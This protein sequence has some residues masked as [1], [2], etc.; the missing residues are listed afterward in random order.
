VKIVRTVTG[1]ALDLVW[2][3]IAS[4][5]DR[6]AALAIMDQA[7]MS[8]KPFLSHQ[9]ICCDDCSTREAAKTC[10]PANAGT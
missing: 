10:R 9:C 2:L 3:E 4:G 6:D 1:A 7:R 8:A 5:P